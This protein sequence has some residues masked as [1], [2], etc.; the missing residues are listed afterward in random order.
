MAV[1]TAFFC[2]ACK[3]SSRR[4]VFMQPRKEHRVNAVS[5]KKSWYGVERASLSRSS[6]NNTAYIIFRYLA[7]G[8]DLSTTTLKNG[9]RSTDLQPRTVQDGE[10]CFNGRVGKSATTK[11]WFEI[12]AGRSTASETPW[13]R[14]RPPGN[15]FG[16]MTRSSVPLS[17]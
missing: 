12:T 15:V 5:Q 13:Q 7:P 10:R 11:P 8:R 2:D 3:W 1:T 9:I 17:W 16:T 14:Q 4:D 6:Q